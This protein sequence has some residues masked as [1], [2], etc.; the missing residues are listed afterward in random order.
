MECVFALLGFVGIV[1]AVSRATPGGFLLAVLLLWPTASFLAAPYNSLSAQRA[2]LPDELR[3]RRQT[4]YLRYGKRRLTYAIGGLSVA[5]GAA[6]LALGLFVPGPATIV[7]PQLVGP[8]VDF[9]HHLLDVDDDHVGDGHVLPDAD[10]VR[11]DRRP[12]R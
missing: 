10:G 3:E 11:R 12:D 6:A 1:G 9:S 8:D 4:E 5:S 7:A 2:A